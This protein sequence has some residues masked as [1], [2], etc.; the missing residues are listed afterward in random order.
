M[1]FPINAAMLLAGAAT[2][3]LFAG[4]ASQAQEQAKAIFAGGCFWCV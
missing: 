1:R 4:G 3:I 2:A